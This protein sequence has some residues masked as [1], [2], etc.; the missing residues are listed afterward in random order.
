MSVFR[1]A[2]LIFSVLAAAP[3]NAKSADRQ[4]V[5]HGV[6]A[7]MAAM[8]ANENAK[9]CFAGVNIMLAG[10]ES[11]SKG[12]ETEYFVRSGALKEGSEHYGLFVQGRGM[13]GPR[14]RLITDYFNRCLDEY[15]KI[16]TSQ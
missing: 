16:S 11:K 7:H 8:A 14:D 9:A 10:Y 4:D 12:V 6:T 5:A 3:S 15:L 13:A 1:A 2:V